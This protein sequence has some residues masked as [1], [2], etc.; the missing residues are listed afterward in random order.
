MPTLCPFGGLIITLTEKPAVEFDLDLPLGL[1]GTV[2]AIIEDFVEKLL[3]EILGRRWVAERIVIRSADEEEPLKIP[4]GET[5]TPVVRRQ[6]S[7]S[8]QHRLGLRHGQAR[9]ERRR[10]R[11]DVQ[12]GLL[13]RMYIKSKGKGKTNTEVIDNNNDPTWNHTVYMLVDDMNER[14]SRWLSWTKTLCPTSSSAKRS[15][16][17]SPSTS[18]P[19]RARIWIDF[20]ETEKRNGSYKRGPMR[21]LLDV[22][23][24]PFDATAASMPLSPETM[25]RT[26][27][28]T[29]AK[30]KGS[31]C[32][33]ACSSRRRA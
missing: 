27:S 29:L 9:R 32:S 19:T 24:I 31:A 33:P 4:N 28:A 14:S 22:T 20:P 8:P 5:V 18:P 23:Y 13:R 15:S 16:T 26:R 11:S 21:L 30:L 6:R 10:H 7:D 12:G 1:E 2:T 3:S 25:H 17:S